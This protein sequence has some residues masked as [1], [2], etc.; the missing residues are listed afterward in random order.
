MDRLAVSL[1][2]SRTV[3]TDQC[4]TLT[5][6]LSHT[7]FSPSHLHVPD[8]PD[9]AHCCCL[10][11]LLVIPSL[12]PF[13]LPSPPFPLPPPPSHPS[14]PLPPQL[15]LSTNVGRDYARDEYAFDSKQQRGVTVATSELYFIANSRALHHQGQGSRKG[16][17][18]GAGNGNGK[19]AGAEE[20][21]HQPG[22]FEKEE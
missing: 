7:P 5:L 2:G 22:D 16:N 15:H 18:K 13:S 4:T 9:S 1:A 14:P 12:T 19:G 6:A 10:R 11:T 20:T 3:L 17:G 21:R 8:L